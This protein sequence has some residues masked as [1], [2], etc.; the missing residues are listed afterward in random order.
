MAF[1][2]A[3]IKGDGHGL[4]FAVVETLSKLKIVITV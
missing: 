1:K 4:D 2:A 3:Y